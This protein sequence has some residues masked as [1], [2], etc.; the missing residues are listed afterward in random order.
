MNTKL[1]FVTDTLTV[2]Q[3][4]NLDILGYTVDCPHVI[5]FNGV[6]LVDHYTISYITTSHELYK[7]VDF[8]S[9]YLKRDLP[10]STVNLGN[11]GEYMGN[12]RYSFSYYVAE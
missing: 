1:T 6:R 7:I 3:M 9:A 8:L 12:F 4:L 11:N 10:Y 2:P 5:R